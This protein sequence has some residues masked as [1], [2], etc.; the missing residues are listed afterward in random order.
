MDWAEAQ[1]HSAQRLGQ[2]VHNRVIC[3]GDAACAVPPFGG[4]GAQGGLRDANNLGWKLAAVLHGKAARHG[5]DRA[6]LFRPDGHVTAAFARPTTEGI[7]AARD[8][9]L[10]RLFHKETA[11]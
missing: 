3:A 4:L 5:S 6:Y 11:A 7:T 9:A 10:G 1:V 2:L 8:R